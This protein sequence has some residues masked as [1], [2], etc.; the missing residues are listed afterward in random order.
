MPYAL[1]EKDDQ[2]SRSFPTRDE[3]WEHAEDAGLVVEANGKAAL[4]DHYSIKP[5][6]ADPIPQAQSD[7]W[8]LPKV[9][10]R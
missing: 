10:A 7:D 3:V 6:M 9:R 2:L 1:F 8:Q 4:E 5:C